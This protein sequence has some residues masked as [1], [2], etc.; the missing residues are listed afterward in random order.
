MSL[1]QGALSVRGL[2]LGQLG[3]PATSVTTYQGY[4]KYRVSEDIIYT[5]AKA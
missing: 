5:T 2:K 3:C 1:L 4:V